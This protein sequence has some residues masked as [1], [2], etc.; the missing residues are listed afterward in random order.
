[1]T[2]FITNGLATFFFLY[3]IVTAGT[4][5]G[6]GPQT[7]T[8]DVELYPF[9]IKNDH[10]ETT[11]SHS[12]FT[13][14][15]KSYYPLSEIVNT[16]NGS[17]SIVDPQDISIKVQP[18]FG[19]HYHAYALDHLFVNEQ[20]KPALTFKETVDA[21][22]AILIES[23]TG[24]VLFSKNS[25]ETLYPASTTKIMTALLAL[26]YGNLDDIVVVSE[27]VLNIPYDSSRAHI[28]PGDVMTLEQLLYGM[29]IPS[30]ND[31]AVAIAIHIA[32][33]EQAFVEMMNEKASQL[34]ASNTQFTNPHGYHNPEQYTTAE[35]LAKIGFEAAKLKHYIPLIST[36]RYRATFSNEEG[37][38]VIRNWRSTNQHI[39]E[40]S[41]FYNPEITGGKTGFTT[42]ARYTLVSYASKA[43]YD[44]VAVILRGRPTERY[45][46][47]EIL[48]ERAFAERERYNEKNKQTIHVSYHPA[49]MTFG[50]KKVISKQPLLLYNNQFYIPEEQVEEI[51]QQ[52]NET[53]KL[54]KSIKQLMFPMVKD[55]Q[56]NNRKIFIP[57]HSLYSLFDFRK[58]DLQIQPLSFI[59]LDKK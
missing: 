27:D 25:R 30:G 51:F 19:D 21:D 23:N 2:R 40:N 48:F 17:L 7:K 3:M 20:K 31:A 44:Y 24:N 4:A 38:T 59:T 45:L 29:M 16:F 43:G 42:P 14:Q 9:S 52:L 46:D 6:Q 33:S 41:L 58:S 5:F 55:V 56:V 13:F 28:K 36:A 54:T 47:T 12:M 10:N 32:G 18:L 50:N 15:G 8:I 57:M 1:M 34:G 11:A 49:T 22:A 35:D 39:R 37:E 26:E 53:A